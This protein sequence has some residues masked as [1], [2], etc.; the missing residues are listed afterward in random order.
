MRTTLDLDESVL[1][2]A[3]ALARDEGISLG[4][5]VSRLARAGLDVHIGSITKTGFPV[6]APRDDAHPITLNLVNELR[7]GD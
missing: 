4:T 3:R 5:A 7:D 6:F 2:A 1:T